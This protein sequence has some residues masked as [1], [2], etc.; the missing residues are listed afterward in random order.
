MI[1]GDSC[2]HGLLLSLFRTSR[3]W[4]DGPIFEIECRHKCLRRNTEC[5][6]NGNFKV[7]KAV[8]RNRISVRRHNLEVRPRLVENFYRFA[9][10]LRR[11]VGVAQRHP[12]IAVTQQLSDGVEING[13]HREA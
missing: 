2:T 1:T 12:I 9:P 11:K 13:P 6:W 3:L 4:L 7:D 5:S 8:R 10:M